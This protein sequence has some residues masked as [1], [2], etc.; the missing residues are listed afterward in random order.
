MN[1]LFAVYLFIY[2]VE[3]EENSMN[4]VVYCHVKN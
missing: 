1:F 4:F 3:E 2:V